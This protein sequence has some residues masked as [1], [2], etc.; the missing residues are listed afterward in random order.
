MKEV[1]V[2]V[3]VWGAL[4]FPAAALVFGVCRGVRALVFRVWSLRRSS[5]YLAWFRQCRSL[6]TVRV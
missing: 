3:L 2:W 6:R 1:R 5:E 4:G